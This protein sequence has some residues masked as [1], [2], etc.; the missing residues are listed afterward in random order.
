MKKSVFSVFIL[1]MTVS[2]VVAAP[3]GVPGASV[4]ADQ[5]TMGVELDFLI[6]RDIDGASKDLEGM[7]LFARG[8]I[9]VTKRIDLFVR[10]GFGRFEIGGSD[11]DT[12]PAYGL[13]AKVTWAAIPDANLKIGS[14]MQMTQIRADQKGA[15]ASYKAYD[16]A[17]GVFMD[18]PSFQ[19]GGA[20]LST[21]GGL[22]FSSA[23]IEVVSA[24]PGAF[25]ENGSYG[26]FAGVLM[27]MNQRATAGIELRLIDQTA[28]SLYTAFPF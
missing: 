4:G 14:V 3:I 9:G 7:N 1:L 20:T 11:T 13:G 19:Q 17:L 28:V 22:V 15:R 25:K 6:D 10:L 8:D 2:T 23:D 24:S 27:D 16:L 18:K 5:S 26:F 21:Y 12:G